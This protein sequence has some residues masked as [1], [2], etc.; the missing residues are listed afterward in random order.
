MEADRE[1]RMHEFS[2]AIQAY[3]DR[4]P[5]N[6]ASDSKANQKWGF[7]DPE[8]IAKQKD[9]AVDINLDIKLFV[10]ENYSCLQS[11]RTVA[12]IFHGISSPKYT[13]YEWGRNQYWG[14]MAHF[15]FKQIAKLG[16]KALIDY[17]SK[18]GPKK[19]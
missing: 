15:N 5:A 18:H 6:E 16:D 19:Q 10:R 13:A 7:R 3:F 1:G 12:R 4:I 14:K 9:G 17:K 8:L 11:G 2:T